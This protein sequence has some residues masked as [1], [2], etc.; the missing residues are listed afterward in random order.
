RASGGAVESALTRML[1]H[2]R[3]RRDCRPREHFGVPLNRLRLHGENLPGRADADGDVTR[4]SVRKERRLC[5]QKP[6]QR[7]PPIRSIAATTATASDDSG[8]TCNTEGT[9]STDSTS[10][11]LPS[12]SV[13]GT[14]PAIRH[15]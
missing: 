1:M 9:A 7:A 15:S 11:A 12:W 13:R 14:C 2:I 3:H 10:N 5:V 4:P 6:A 8:L